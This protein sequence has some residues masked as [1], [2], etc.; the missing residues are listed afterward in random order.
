M[1]LNLKIGNSTVKYEHLNKKM[2]KVFVF[3]IWHDL[4]Y[5]TQKHYDLGMRKELQNLF[6]LQA[7]LSKM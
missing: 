7:K 5:Y 2:N 3:Y 4:E 1:N 6:C